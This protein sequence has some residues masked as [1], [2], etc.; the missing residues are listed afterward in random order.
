[1]LCNF[2]LVKISIQKFNSQFEKKYAVNLFINTC[3]F[4]GISFLDFMFN[5][6]D[7]WILGKKIY[8]FVMVASFFVKRLILTGSTQQLWKSMKNGYLR[9]KLINWQYLKAMHN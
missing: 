5:L 7:T 6:A 1:M 2:V 3:N 8:L 4:V 9:K